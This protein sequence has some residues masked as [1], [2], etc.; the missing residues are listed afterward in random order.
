MGTR[1]G[2]PTGR[3]HAT[4]F[5]DYDDDGDADLWVANDG[6]R[7]RVLRND[8]SQGD[9]KFTPVAKAMDVDTVGNWMGFAVGDYNGDNALDVFVTNAGYHL[10]L[11]PAQETPGGDCAYQHQFEWGTCLHFLL[12]NGGTREMAGVGTVGLFS[13]VAS[14]T[15][16]SPSS[17]MV[18]DSLDPENIH[19]FW[20]APTG[21]AAYDFGY[22]AT[23][24][25]FDNDGAQD[26]YWLGSEIARGEGPG[27][28]VYPGAGRMLRGDGQGAFEDITVRAGL[29]DVLVNYHNSLD[30]SDPGVKAIAGDI[31]TRFHENGKGLAHG[32]LNGDGYVDLIGTNSSG[33]CVGRNP[34]LYHTSQRTYVRVAERWGREPLD[35]HTPAGTHGHRRHG[36]QRRWY[37]RTRIC[38]DYPQG[39][40]WARGPGAGS[41]RRFELPV[42]GQHR[43]GVRRWDRDGSNG[44]HHS[45][46]QRQNA[47]HR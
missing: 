18:P 8:S 2:D 26:L 14:A 47:G 33:A 37:R 12:R 24:F 6:D 10:L 46:A 38:E 22:G 39:W 30:P 15:E 44:G 5:F 25:D 41:A 34:R 42:D 19:P 21:L 23:F 7:L 3:T 45:M 27:G 11:R 43:A 9:I 4:L 35:D 29:L 31:R 17:V 36:Q 40:K 16:V 1:I 20:E 32:D 28:E 13:D